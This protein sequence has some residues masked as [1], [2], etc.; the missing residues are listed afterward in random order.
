MSRK[1]HDV[2]AYHL[3]TYNSSCMSLYDNLLQ[4]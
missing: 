2:A 4:T 3:P 1:K